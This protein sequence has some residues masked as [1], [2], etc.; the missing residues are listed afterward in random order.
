VRS[1]ERAALLL[2]AES[3][4][5]HVN[6]RV[7][8]ILAVLDSSEPFENIDIVLALLRIALLLGHDTLRRRLNGWLVE[9]TDVVDG[10]ESVRWRGEPLH[11]NRVV[12]G[13]RRYLRERRTE[14]L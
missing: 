2:D 7:R 11:L 14:A 1:L 4:R 9:H 10:I 12:D 3:A 13:L 5:R 6:V 8:R